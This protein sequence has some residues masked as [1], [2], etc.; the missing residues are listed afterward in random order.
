LFFLKRAEAVGRAFRFLARVG[1]MGHGSPP[2][3]PGHG[4][5]ARRGCAVG[6]PAT[7]LVTSPGGDGGRGLVGGGL[8]SGRWNFLSRLAPGATHPAPHGTTWGAWPVA[9]AQDRLP[10]GSQ[11]PSRI[12]DRNTSQTVRG[13]RHL[14]STLTW[15]RRHHR[16]HRAAARA[17]VGPSAAETPA[18]QRPQGLRGDN[19][20]T[21][22]P[23]PWAAEDLPGPLGRSG[24]IFAPSVRGGPQRIGKSGQIQAVWF[25]GPDDPRDGARLCRGFVGSRG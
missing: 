13:M 12:S 7:E 14:P 15:S 16:A 9:R 23:A 8:H 11:R 22:W 2:H 19:R 6:R 10:P 4:S 17:P 18:K 3:P 24:Q 21:D 5:G 1:D 25:S 20:R